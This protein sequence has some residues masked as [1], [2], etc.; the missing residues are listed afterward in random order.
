[1]NYK[2]VGR[3]EEDSLEITGGKRG[4]GRF[5]R[6]REEGEEGGREGEVEEVRGK[7]GRSGLQKI[8]RNERQGRREP[9]NFSACKSWKSR[10]L[11]RSRM[12]KKFRLDKKIIILACSEIDVNRLI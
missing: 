10:L 5:K 7:G 6:V 4:R 11:R 3:E 8:C 12:E 1:M 2:R 9:E